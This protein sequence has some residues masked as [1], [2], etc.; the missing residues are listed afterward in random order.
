MRRLW[1]EESVTFEGEFYRYRE[2]SISPRP[3]QDPLPLSIGGSSEAAI[4]RTAALGTG[5]VAGIQV[6]EEVGPV[7]SRIRKLADEAGRPLDPEHFGA[8]VSY[9]FGSMDDPLIQRTLK[10]FKRFQPGLDPEKFFAVGGAEAVL[11]RIEE[12]RQGFVPLV[13]PLTLFAHHFRKDAPEW[14]GQQTYLNPYPAELMLR[15]HV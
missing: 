5:W 6:P 11:E 12:Y 4:L 10:G 1:S 7:V 8:G 2:A 3:L 9:R 14:V 15:N 13:V